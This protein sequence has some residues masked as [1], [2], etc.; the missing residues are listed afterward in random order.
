MPKQAPKQARNRKKGDFEPGNKTGP[1]WK[2][3]QSGNPKGR[4]RTRYLSK[5]AIEWLGSASEKD[6]NLTNAEAIIAAVG[7]KA[8]NGDV[9]A[10]A[11]LADRTEGKPRQAVEI[12]TDDR[13]RQVIEKALPMLTATGL[14]E[15]EAKRYLA[16]F[17]PEVSTWI[18]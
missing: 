5:A 15:D 14:S 11:W 9:Y 10:A 13:M 2:K 6:P 12:S 3:G 1:R 17:V 16:E 18:N 7:K 4:P 8:L